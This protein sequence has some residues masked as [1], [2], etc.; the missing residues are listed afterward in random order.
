MEITMAKEVMKKES[1]ESLDL[2]LFEGMDT[3]FEGTSSQTF[4]TPFVKILQAMSPELKKSDPKY[5]QGAEQGQFCNTATNDATDTI[6][7]VIL[8]LEHSLV[9]WGP[10]RGGLVGRFPKS[11]EDEIV[12]KRDGVKKWDASGNDVVDTIELF[13]LDINNPGSVFVF[14][15]ST[16]S[17][18]HGKSL[19]TRMRV[20]RVDGQQIKVSWA[21]VWKLSTVEE[22]ND[23]GSWYTVGSTPEFV[24]LITKQ[25][26]EEFIIPAKEML[27]T[28]ETDYSV[29]DAHVATADDVTY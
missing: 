24:R 23:K 25:E 7:V 20:L 9:V 26:A 13:C 15:L 27:K 2:T 22:S 18:K 11:Q 21:G 1:N 10:D 16:T 12:V 5:I 14:P 3:G 17:L 8:K 28:A 4:K 6:E 19:A 29:V